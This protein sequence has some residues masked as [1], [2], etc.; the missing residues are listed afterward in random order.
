VKKL[1]SRKLGLSILAALLPIICQVLV[2]D[3]PTEKIVVSV[4]GLLGGVLGIAAEDVQKIKQGVHED[5]Q[6]QAEEADASA[7]G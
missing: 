6:A 2:P 4:V 5:Y 3:M 1:L 7:E